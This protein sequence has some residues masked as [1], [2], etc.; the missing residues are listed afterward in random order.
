MALLGAAN[1]DEAEFA[2][3]GEARL[4]SRGQP[5]P[6]LRRR[7]P[8]LP[9]LAPRPPRA[10]RRAAGVAPP[11][12]RLLASS[13]ASSSTTP[14]ASAR[15]TRF[16]MVLGSARE[17][18]SGSTVDRD[19]DR[20]PAARLGVRRVARL[21]VVADRRR[22]SRRGRTG[23]RCSSTPTPAARDQVRMLGVQASLVAAGSL[24]PDVVRSLARR[25]QL[26]RR[27]LAVEGHRAL[28]ANER[29]LPPSVRRLVDRELAAGSTSAEASL[30]LARSRQAIDDAPPVFGTIH[31]RRLLAAVDRARRPPR[32]SP[33]RRRRRRRPGPHGA[34]RAPDED[35]DD[36]DL[37][38]LLSSPVGGG[39]A[40]GRLL[41]RLLQPGAA[42]GRRRSARRRRPDPRRGGR[43]R[44]RAS[45]RGVRH[46]RRR[47][48]G[49]RRL[50]AAAARAYPEW[51]VHRR[52]YRPDWCTVVEIDPPA[53]DG[54][55]A[56][57]ARR[58][59]R[60]AARSPASA[61]A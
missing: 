9:R 49:H 59:S 3:G 37:G 18:L 10:A 32:P 7:H 52:R 35:D 36:E 16:P 12:P 47:A 48:R 14:P 31:A 21:E 41:R 56:T 20:P 2:D 17:R 50:R 46:R 11:H 40:V 42:A 13:P 22:A 60:C 19:L 26:A 39:G 6:G 1:V 8:P 5:A 25:P 15:S 44:S 24:E 23:R 55:A 54:A 61:S 38:H 33:R 4:G 58:R 28:A 51:D 57:H 29:C 53:G 43:A 27:Y 45:R 30:E 34:G